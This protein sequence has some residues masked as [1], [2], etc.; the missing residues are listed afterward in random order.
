MCEHGRSEICCDLEKFYLV[1]PFAIHDFTGNIWERVEISFS[2][3][4]QL[5]KEPLEGLKILHAMGIIH[6]DIRPKNMLVVSY[7][8]PR[9][10]LCDYGKAIE[11]KE[12][13]DTRIG[14][15]HTLAPEVWTTAESGPYTANIDTW[16]YGYAI[17]EI[18][19]YKS[20]DNSKITRKRLSSIFAKLASLH[21]KK[22]RV[23]FSLIWLQSFLYGNLGTAGRPNKLF[24]MN[25]GSLW[26]ETR[27]KDIMP[28]WV[29]RKAR[30]F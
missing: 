10:A 4:M 14:P 12:A 19:G 29:I 11:A 8:P 18:L 9:A 30:D 7:D 22:L 16:A 20:P 1:M 25:A 3:K 27:I 5:L 24:S 17:A 2:A 28:W 26:R 6:R 21:G 23:K 13:T 15:V